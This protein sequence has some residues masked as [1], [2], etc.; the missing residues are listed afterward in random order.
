VNARS[1]MVLAALV[2]FQLSGVVVSDAWMAVSLGSPQTAVPISERP[3]YAPDGSEVAFWTDWRG[4][5][6]IWAVSTVNG[7]LRPIVADPNV[8][9][10]EPAWSPTGSWIAFK[11]NRGGNLNIWLVRP[12]GSGLTQLTQ[13]TTGRTR[14]DQPTW[15]PDG[16]QIAFVSDRDGVGNV[17]VIN[18]NGS[19]LRRVTTP[20]PPRSRSH[21]D[22]SPDGS[23]IVFSEGICSK[24]GAG[25][26]CS[27]SRLLIMNTDGTGL[28]QL[29]TD[30]FSDTNPSWGGPGILFQSTRARLNIWMIQPDGSGLRAIPNAVGLSPTWSPDGTKFA[31]SGNYDISEFNFLN[32]MIRPLVELKGY[33]IPIDIMPGVSPKVISLREVAQISVA[34]LSGAGAD[35]MQQLDL[36]SLTFG[37]AG[38]ERS[39]NSCAVAGV[40][41][42]CSFK[43]GMTGFRPGDTE[44]ILRVRKVVGDSRIP[45]EGRGTV[46]IVP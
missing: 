18:A 45:L 32:G 23:Q 28:R 44:G 7:R 17:W 38:D 13:P 46:Q 37:R 20:N 40:N 35:L 14:Y 8:N 2:T 15:S 6:E 9:A 39:L 5:S 27:G 42:V 24:V 34:L 11:S 25:H 21:P 31:F 22:F 30:G 36:T 26:L 41:L 16:A 29:T 19:G 3:S 43:M 4:K 1:R 10:S 33:F 12:D